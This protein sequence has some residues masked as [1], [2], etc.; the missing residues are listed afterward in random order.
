MLHAL[1]EAFVIFEAET[2]LGCRFGP[3]RNNYKKG[4]GLFLIAKICL[5]LIYF[6]SSL[7]ILPGDEI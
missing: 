6:L 5:C 4:T 3:E 1:K 2:E 7:Q